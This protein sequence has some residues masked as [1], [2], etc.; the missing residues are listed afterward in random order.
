MSSHNPKQGK[1]L[2]KDIIEG[3]Q[4]SVMV[5]KQEE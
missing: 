5:M 2:N 1:T 4:N 3:L